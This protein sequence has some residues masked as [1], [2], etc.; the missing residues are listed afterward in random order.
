[1]S[2]TLLVAMFVVSGVVQSGQEL[3]DHVRKAGSAEV[4]VIRDYPP[5]DLKTLV[6]DAELI[7]RVVIVSSNASMIGDQ[8][9]TDSKAQVLTVV[10]GAQSVE[11]TTITVRKPGGKVALEGGIVTASD[12]DFAPFEIGEEYVLFLKST[13]QGNFEVRFGGQGAFKV[14][15]GKVAQVSRNIGTWN[16]ERGRIDVLQ[17]FEEIG[18]ASKNQ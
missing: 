18:A 15:Q 17:L 12:P 9:S 14:T 16:R 7:A 6:R 13:I 8:I 5:V 10:K 11:H 2:S 1:M 3:R 4:V